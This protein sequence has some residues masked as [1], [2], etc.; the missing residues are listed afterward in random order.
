MHYELIKL[1]RKEIAEKVSYYRS[2]NSQ[3][4]PHFWGNIRQLVIDLF[5]RPSNNNKCCNCC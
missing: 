5:P 2:G 3:H 1:K 4:A